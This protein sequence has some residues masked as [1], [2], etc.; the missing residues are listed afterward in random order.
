MVRVV[1]WLGAVLLIRRRRRRGVGCGDSSAAVAERGAAHVAA[2]EARAATG[3][4]LFVDLDTLTRNAAASVAAWETPLARVTTRHAHTLANIEE[5]MVRG[6]GDE[7]FP[8]ASG[9]GLTPRG[10]VATIRD[11]ALAERDRVQQAVAGR[12]AEPT[13]GPGA[14]APDRGLPRAA[15]VGLCCQ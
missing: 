5:A 7:H 2:A 10:I 3:A 8:V 13:A 15:P 1:V 14:A 4:P 9:A 6:T 12:E 11:A